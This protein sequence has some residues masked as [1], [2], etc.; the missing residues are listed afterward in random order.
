[1]RFR[2]G[3]VAK[4][5]LLR[6]SSSFT[7]FGNVHISLVGALDFANLGISSMIFE[8][9]LKYFKISDF[10]ILE[11]VFF[12]SLFAFAFFPC[13]GAL[14]EPDVRLVRQN[15]WFLAS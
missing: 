2:S 11:C 9:F 12:C 15:K 1:M 6:F 8:R 7:A 13:L 3:G 14:L 4:I 10:R 5:D